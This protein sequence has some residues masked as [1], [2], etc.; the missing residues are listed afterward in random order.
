MGRRDPETIASSGWGKLA[1]LLFAKVHVSLVS[2][3][4]TVLFH[5]QWGEFNVLVSIRFQ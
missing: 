1:E 5:I 3:T 2:S 4:D